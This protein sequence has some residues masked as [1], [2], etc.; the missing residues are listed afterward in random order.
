MRRLLRWVAWTAA[1]VLLLAAV[2]AVG[3]YL[4]SERILRR[5]YASA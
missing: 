4:G 2:I 1:A 3:V 5:T